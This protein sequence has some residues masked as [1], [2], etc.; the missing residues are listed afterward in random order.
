MALLYFAA[1]VNHFI[2]PEFYLPVMPEWMPVKMFLIYVSGFAELLLGI[3]LVF[4][5]T[6]KFAAQLILVMLVIFLFLIHIPQT[7]DFYKT[8]N[9]DFVFSL[10]RIAVQ[11]LLIAWAWIYT[12][13]KFKTD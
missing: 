7:I 4:N 13:G 2:N 9:K 6:Q 3:L 8:G 12:K 11:F 5:H 10:I 1:G